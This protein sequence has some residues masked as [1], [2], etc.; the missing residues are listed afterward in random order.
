MKF[1]ENEMVFLNSI[2]EGD[3]VFGIP[4]R[5]CI[6]Q[7][8]EK[9]IENT[10]QG[11]IQKGILKSKSVL[12]EQGV[13][14]AR[15]LELYKESK[16]HI[17]I[18]YIHIALIEGA[19]SIVIIPA[20]NESEEYELLRIPRVALL[21]V[22]LKQYPVLRGRKYGMEKQTQIRKYEEFLNI[23][24]KYEGNLLVGTFYEGKMKSE[25]VYYWKGK[26]LWCY[27]L[28]TQINKEKDFVQV[29]KEMLRLLQIETEMYDNAE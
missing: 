15:A 25:Q 8:K 26:E 24:K 2:T 13:L 23:L 16:T 28:E 5:F 11:L 18:N 1:T 3:T 20:Y 19:D 12:S 17:I 10:I 22:L 6:K 7:E 29:R 27:D 4:L 14:P 9:E 21:Y